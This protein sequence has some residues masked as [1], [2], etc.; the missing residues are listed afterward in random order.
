MLKKLFDLKSKL[1]PLGFGIFIVTSFM[2]IY[3][4]NLTL[5]FLLL[6]VLIQTATF[7]FY[8]YI[9]T[10]SQ[11]MQYI[12][13]IGSFVAMLLLMV[14]IGS[15]YNT[16][17]MIDFM[18]WFLSPQSVVEYSLQYI[19]VILVGLD[20]FIASTIYYFTQVRYRMLTTFFLF[21]MPFAIFTKEQ[22][23][24]PTA[25]IILLI[26]L[27]FS[28]MIVCGQNNL[29]KQNSVKV[30][31]NSSYI[32]SVG[33]F[34]LTFLLV[35][36]AVPKPQI[37]ADRDTFENL[38]NAN[39][40]TN[41]LL[42]Q[43]GNFTDT[44]NGGTGFNYISSN[45]VMFTAETSETVALKSRTFS[46]YNFNK[47]VWL[48]T[49]GVKS[50]IENLDIDT[51]LN[52]G[53]NQTSLV[54]Y[55]RYGNELSSDY[56][57]DFLESLNPAELLNAIAFACNKDNTFAE[58][59]NLNK[60]IDE[61]TS[62]NTSIKKVTVT[63]KYRRFSIVLNPTNTFKITPESD[64]YAT[65][66]STCSGLYYALYDVNIDD[67]FV[68][69]QKYSMDYYSSDVMYSSNAFSILKQLNFNSYGKFLDDLKTLTRGSQF[70]S[71]VDSYLQD[72]NNA[73][74][75][76]QVFTGLNN[77]KI[78]ALAESIT[79]GCN[80]DVEKALAL[81]N[82]F[83]SNGYT[84][85]AEYQQPKGSTIESFLFETKTGACYEYSTSMV[86]MAR[87]LG[88]PARYAEGFLVYNGSNSNET[89]DVTANSSHAFPEVY[90][91]GYG[92]C[93][94]EP[95]QVLLTS[96]D[97]AKSIKLSQNY[98]IFIVS[99]VLVAI[100][101]LCG[102]F[103]AFVYP[104]LYEKHFRR[105]VLRKPLETALILI[106]DRIRKLAKLPNT[107]TLEELQGS[108]KSS[109]NVDISSIVA[110]CNRVFY[111]N[112][113]QTESI[114]ACLDVYILLYSAILQTNKE[115]KKS[116]KRKKKV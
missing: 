65:M 50:S 28:T 63:D 92:W 21:L 88:L 59:Y 40:F 81:Q 85:D 14:I 108:L 72:Y 94:F 89:I 7:I 104:K 33:A 95:T 4:D 74:I 20:F 76:S 16:S 10:K 77:D 107:Q 114:Q 35:A 62:F 24:M 19:F 1:V 98:E 57:N 15:L 66:V 73:L 47:N 39:S 32:K 86:L 51:T 49:D 82:Y 29:Y 37:D 64:F 115:L 71:V 43:L 5:V 101:V 13:I 103:M 56:N 52:C 97:D 80:S 46:S 55:D 78:S 102:M 60:V 61:D 84:Y 54:N 11:I 79:K 90:I 58:N 111:G 113:K 45:Q 25:F 27:Y 87:A 18:V 31:E 75:Y 6:S 116:R 93:Y 112:A 34:V 8:D 69:I 100:A 12:S 17:N 26:V 44:S 91:S 67:S 36:S 38:I 2:Y 110:V 106:V 30:L 9:S 23:D 105:K 3:D 53:N 70:E 68:N 48:R 42:A 96:E 99:C 22:E 83:I 109:Y 41:Y